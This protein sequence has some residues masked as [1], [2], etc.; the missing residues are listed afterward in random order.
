MKR[1]RSWKKCNCPCCGNWNS[2][3][4]G[5]YRSRNIL[6]TRELAKAYEDNYMLSYWDY[7]WGHMD[8]YEDW[9]DLTDY[10]FYRWQEFS[11]TE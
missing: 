3:K 5:A 6:Q 9:M 7:D 10:E 1:T 8:D 2:A 11:E 4:I